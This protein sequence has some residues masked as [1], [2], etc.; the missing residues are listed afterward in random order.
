MKNYTEEL[1]YWY[2]RF[3]GF[4]LINNHVVHRAGEP[5]FDEWN[6]N[7]AAAHSDNDLLGIRTKFVSEGV[8]NPH[9]FCHV[10]NEIA[11]VNT[12]IVGVI[13]EVKGGMNDLPHNN[14]LYS[15]ISRLGI[16]NH[17]EAIHEFLQNNS[18]FIDQE[19]GIAHDANERF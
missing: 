1:A 2:F 12:N 19:N 13:C 14:N 9:H 8:G 5:N 15:Q 7:Q 16:T 10:L 18:L 11:P 17:V 3:N 4:F 6:H